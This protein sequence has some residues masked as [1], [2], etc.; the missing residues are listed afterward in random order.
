MKRRKKDPA[1]LLS[2]E[3]II[4]LLNP[5]KATNDGN[6]GDS[7]SNENNEGGEDNGVEGEEVLDKSFIS[8]DVEIERQLTF[9][10]IENAGR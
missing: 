6:N 2:D 1:E 7:E 4:A 10:E 9:T 3:K 5:D 8:L